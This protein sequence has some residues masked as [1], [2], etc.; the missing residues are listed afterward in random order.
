MTK[1]NFE[2]VKSYGTPGKVIIRQYTQ[3]DSPTSA[4]PK[5]IE[6][7]KLEEAEYLRDQLNKIISEM[8]VKY[9]GYEKRNS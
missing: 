4:I 5:D 2:I 3:P 7:T 6:I 8:R 1:Y 9:A